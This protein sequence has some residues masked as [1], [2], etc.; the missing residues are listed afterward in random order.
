[1]RPGRMS[2]RPVPAS[3]AT[4]GLEAVSCPFDVERAVDL[5][6][7]RERGEQRAELAVRRV[8]ARGERARLQVVARVD[9]DRLI[10]DDGAAVLERDLLP[11]AAHAAPRRGSARAR[12]SSRR[13]SSAAF[14]VMRSGSSCTSRDSTWKRPESG[15]RSGGSSS[16]S[17]ARSIADLRTWT[18]R[19]APGQLEAERNHVRADLHQRLAHGREVRLVAERARDRERCALGL[20]EDPRLL[21]ARV[22]QI[23]RVALA[24][25]CVAARGPRDHQVPRAHEQVGHVDVRLRRA[26]PAA[27]DLDLELAAG[28]A[29]DLLRDA[30]AAAQRR[31]IGAELALG[32]DLGRLSRKTREPRLAVAKL[33]ESRKVDVEAEGSRAVEREPAGDVPVLDQ[34]RPRLDA[35]VVDRDP[36]DRQGQPVGGSLL[37]RLA[38]RRLDGRARLRRGW[39]G[40]GRG[41]GQDGSSGSVQRHAHARRLDLERAQHDLPR[42]QRQ[43][44][45]AKPQLRD[46]GERPVAR[47][48][49]GDADLARA[50]RRKREERKRDPADR[51]FPA[52]CRADLRLQRLAE[53]FGVEE[54]ERD[55]RED[56]DERRERGG[57]GEGAPQLANSSGASSWWLVRRWKASPARST[58]AS[59]SGRPISCSPTGSPGPVRPHGIESAGRP[60]RFA[61]TV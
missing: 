58:V 55:T 51:R 37:G 22:A 38:L 29:R 40:R 59:S 5:A 32:R 24:E 17:D 3:A 47:L 16:R 61:V 1:M 35:R 34:P 28:P 25:H 50:Q 45:D 33:A 7:P 14:P 9:R 49:T 12:A 36:I 54:V 2:I 56:H 15:G 27:R 19:R 23:E 26:K 11:S 10:A 57:G 52:E 6:A 30:E 20:R 13:A 42:E 18:C 53:L 41:S 60:A 46:L 4:S 48:G 21:D 43:D 39:G 44:R 8:V 31:E